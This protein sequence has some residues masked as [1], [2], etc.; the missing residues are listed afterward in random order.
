MERIMGMDIVLFASKTDAQGNFIGEQGKFNSANP[1]EIRIDVNAGLNIE[2]DMGSLANYVMLRT[3]THEFVHSIEVNADAEYRAL[4]EA[5]F[6]EIRR[7]GKENV[8]NLILIEQEKGGKNEDGSYKLSYDDA[9]HEVLAQSLVDVLPQS[10]FIETLAT[11]HRNIFEKLY[12]A[13]KRFMRTIRHRFEQMTSAIP[14]EAAA[15]KRDVDG[16]MQYAQH[17]V[18][19]FDK[20]ALAAVETVQSRNMDSADAMNNTEAF[21][22]SSVAIRNQIRPPYNE[23]TKAFAEFADGLNAEA[24]ETFDLFYNFYNLSRITNTTN[25]AGKPVKAINISAPFLR[26]DEWNAKISSDAKWGAAAARLAESLPVSVRENMHMNEDGSLTETPLEKEFKMQRSLAQRLVDSLPLEKIDAVYDIEGRKVELPAGKARQSVGGEAYRRAVIGEVRKLFHDGRLKQV[27]IGTLSKDR[28]GSLGFL[29]ANGKTG[30]SGDFTTICPQMMFNRGCF[31]CYRR[32]ALESGVNNK[33]VAERVWYAGEILRIKQ[34]DIDALNENGGLR[35]QSFGDWMP[36]FSAM[37]ADV[38]H[39]AELRGLQVKIITKEPSMIQ[40]LAALRGQGL[41]NNL[42][43]NLSADYAIEKAPA[44][45]NTAGSASLD[46]INPDR[47]FMRD[48]DKQMWWK[49]AMT[50]EEA[51]SFRSKY[52]WVNTR[53]V[54]TDTEEFIRG[55]K[56]PTVDVVTGYHGNIRNYERIDSETGARKVEVE[57]L[58]DAGMPRFVYE[59]G[60]WVTEYEG[61]TS[62]HKQLAQRIREE[63]LFLEY[64]AKVCCQTGR[65]ATCKGKCGQMARSLA[66]KNATNRDSKSRAYWQEHMSSAVED[67]SEASP[68]VDSLVAEFRQRM[69]N[70]S[71]NNEN[72]TGKVRYMDRVNGYGGFREML[73]KRGLD[74]LSKKLGDRFP[75]SASFDS[76]MRSNNDKLVMETV[77]AGR[78]KREDGES[79]YSAGRKAFRNAYGTKTTVHIDS[80][81]IDADLYIGIVNESVS[82]A[83]GRDSEEILVDVIPS[84]KSILSKSVLLGVERLAHTDNKG[85]GLYGYRMYNLYWY[86]RGNNRELNCLVCTV[87]QNVEKADGHVFRNIENVTINRGLPGNNTD[88]SAPVNDDTYTIAQLYNTVKGISRDDGGL[89]YSQDDARK[90]LFHYTERNDGTRY[91]RRENLTDRA[92]LERVDEIVGA[93]SDRGTVTGDTHGLEVD[94]VAAF[95]G[96]LTEGERDLLAIYTDRLAKLNDLQEQRRE[97]G[98]IYRRFMADPNPNNRDRGEAAATKNRMDILDQ[99]IDRA[100]N[101]LRE[102]ER[103]KAYKSLLT[104][105]RE[106]VQQT[107]R[108]RILTALQLSREKRERS[109]QRRQ[110]KDSIEAI[111][112]V[113][114]MSPEAEEM[115]EHE[116]KHYAD[117]IAKVGMMLS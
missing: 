68:E 34:K 59:N 109:G 5:V 81:D 41:G 76:A 46:H 14:S 77:I 113:Y 89:N 60:E 91:Q 111:K 30:A 43:F 9:S 114:S 96:K 108:G 102:V 13:L 92:V 12:A 101:S 56:D 29:A 18:D 28:W 88:M 57:A 8:E 110:R 63:N 84:V 69:Q 64:Y 35:I 15:L 31:Y 26:V 52:P 95:K 16:A 74:E 83:S 17:I 11:Q 75:L 47:P 105:S 98:R 20:A 44:A 107:E 49:R 51:G 115:W 82:K 78:V 62:T 70:L 32:A 106:L 61:K 86:K 2:N 21:E 67:I 80:I 3:F 99:Q 1:N 22:D 27:S 33:L 85:T 90:Y 19:L 4:K 38:L 24:K 50:V 116:L 93:V 104:K 100:M 40:Y 112:K 45:A 54:A 25:A 6:A 72:P 36:H 42:Y 117:C 73:A 94:E 103:A 66:M 71:R 58:G 39:D 65:C 97:Q 37:L 55:L 7:N 53:I 23:N 10:T 48:E 87:V 79:T